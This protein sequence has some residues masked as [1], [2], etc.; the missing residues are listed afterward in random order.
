MAAWAQWVCSPTLTDVESAQHSQR[1]VRSSPHTGSGLSGVRV[2]SAYAYGEPQWRLTKESFS[3]R[4]VIEMEII[5]SSLLFTFS[6]NYWHPSS[7]VSPDARGWSLYL[8]QLGGFV[9]RQRWFSWK[10]WKLGYSRHY[11]AVYT[12]LKVRAL[13]SLGEIFFFLEK[14]ILDK[15]HY[16][17]KK[18]FLRKKYFWEKIFKNILKIFFAR[19]IPRVESC[20]AYT[21]VH[22]GWHGRGVS[23]SEKR[24]KTNL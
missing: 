1:A 22:R 15:N 17:E 8:T 19:K 16:S 21:H 3:S 4:W 20:R 11:I 5:F 13:L 14:N 10:S 24:I 9:S 6:Y 18:I 23:R 2:R 7:C 12:H